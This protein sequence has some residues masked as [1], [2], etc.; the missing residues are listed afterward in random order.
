MAAPGPI[1]SG[2]T[3]QM[4]RKTMMPA[5]TLLL[6]T[7]AG[8]TLAGATGR[9]DTPIERAQLVGAFR[10]DGELFHVQGLAVHDRRIW[11]TSVDRHSHRGYLH[12]FDRASGRLLRR[13]DLTD[14]P[15]YHVGGLSIA[16]D[17]IWVP[18]AEN[19]PN[20]SA[21]LVEIDA[22][23]LAVRHRIAVGDHIGCL[24]ADDRHL[25]AANWNSE[26]LYVIDRD[27]GRV[28]M[29]RNPSPTR[30]QDIKFVDGQL[31][32]GGYRSLW[33]GTV[34]WIDFP[35]MTVSRSLRAGAIG[36]VRPFG[37]GGPFTGEGLAIEGRDL[38]VAPEDGPARVFRFRLDA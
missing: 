30:Y 37:R 16:G 10:L 35:A 19:R 25:V 8:V 26:K 17:A 2:G 14:G 24:A 21:V 22:D 32:A 11:I 4:I 36:P 20:S 33:S 3:K 38:Y 13:I 9:S 27:T 15:R 7:A 1:A 31:V 12:E 34:D 5:L 6:L 23:T 28:R 29:V 18:V